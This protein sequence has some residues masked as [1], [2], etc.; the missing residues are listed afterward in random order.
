MT[1]YGASCGPSPDASSAHPTWRRASSI[2]YVIIRPAL[3]T[4]VILPVASEPGP[5]RVRSSRPGIAVYSCVM[6]SRVDLSAGCHLR[7]PKRGLARL[8]RTVVR[9]LLT[10][11]G[12][13]SAADG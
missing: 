3:H 9:A 12:Y 1:R 7:G 5:G 13:Q 4:A 10:V 2:Q 6:I 8:R 11:C